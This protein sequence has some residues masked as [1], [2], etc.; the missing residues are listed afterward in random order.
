MAHWRRGDASESRLNDLE[1]MVT[2]Y[3]SKRH[4]HDI[5]GE[6]AFSALGMS[7]RK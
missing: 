2:G 6:C 3:L 4:G 5:E 7:S 1:T